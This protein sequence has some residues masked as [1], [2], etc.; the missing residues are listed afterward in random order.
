VRDGHGGTFRRAREGHRRPRI[1]GEGR[2]NGRV[3]AA[4][5]SGRRG[6]NAWPVSKA[7]TGRVSPADLGRGSRRWAARQEN[8]W[9]VSKV[10]TGRL[11][12]AD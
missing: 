2:T 12:P 5:S 10:R 8:A 1:V 11:S 9:P 3:L 4:P 6:E 7:R